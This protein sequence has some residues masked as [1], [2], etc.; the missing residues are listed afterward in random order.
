MKIRENLT[1]L[2]LVNGIDNLLAPIEVNA[3]APS[4]AP[5]VALGEAD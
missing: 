5:E 1:L 3:A 4:Q 2:I